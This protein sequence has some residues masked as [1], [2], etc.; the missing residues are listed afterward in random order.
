M[1][2]P[3][4]LKTEVHQQARPNPSGV[5]PASHTPREFCSPSPSPDAIRLA[6]LLKKYEQACAAGRWTEAT[7]VAVQALAL[8][9]ACFSKRR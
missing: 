8:D 1:V 4:I 5:V 6:D 2:T 9:P 7:A 3:R